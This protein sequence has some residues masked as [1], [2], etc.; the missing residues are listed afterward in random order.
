MAKPVKDHKSKMIANYV[1]TIYLK[2]FSIYRRTSYN[3][4]WKRYCLKNFY[5]I[6]KKSFE[7]SLTLAN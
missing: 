3:V 2:M 7:A 4:T 6:P 5:D 1:N